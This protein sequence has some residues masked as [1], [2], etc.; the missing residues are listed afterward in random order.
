MQRNRITLNHG[1]SRS[2]HLIVLVEMIVTLGSGAAFANC[3][4][5]ETSE[6]GAALDV[7]AIAACETY[8]P[9]AGHN[10]FAN[11][12][13]AENDKKM[14]HECAN[15]QRKTDTRKVV[16]QKIYRYTGKKH[17]YW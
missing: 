6:T 7:R 3:R 2:K 15:S 17:N 1:S 11:A 12:I 10:D 5:L 13:H 16:M 8:S 9:T 4:H 14:C